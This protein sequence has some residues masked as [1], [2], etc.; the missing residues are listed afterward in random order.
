LHWP[1]QVPPKVSLIPFIEV[2]SGHSA[3][4]GIALAPPTVVL[5][6][7]V[8]VEPDGKTVVCPCIS[9]N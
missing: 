8:N 3:N 5:A 9:I 1:L 6:G 4:I 2:L 7:I